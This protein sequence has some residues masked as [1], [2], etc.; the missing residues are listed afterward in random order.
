MESQRSRVTCMAAH[1][2]QQMSIMLRLPL[3]GLLLSVFYRIGQTYWIVLRPRA[4]GEDDGDVAPDIGCRGSIRDCGVRL[5]LRRVE[6]AGD[7]N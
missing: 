4:Q 6:A 2:R 1:F 7:A 5:Q 3:V